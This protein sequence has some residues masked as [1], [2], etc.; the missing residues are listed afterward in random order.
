MFVE[1]FASYFSLIIPNANS[2]SIHLT[3]YLYYFICPYILFT[4]KYKFY[5][6]KTCFDFIRRETKRCKLDV[7]YLFY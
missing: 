7:Y 5:F 1:T 2:T 4:D 6:V 3:F